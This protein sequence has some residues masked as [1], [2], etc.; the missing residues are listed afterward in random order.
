MDSVHG[1]RS[2]RYDYFFIYAIHFTT[3]SPSFF[4]M[5]ICGSITCFVVLLCVQLKGMTTI[6]R[7]IL[8]WLSDSFQDL[9]EAV[10][11]N[12]SEDSNPNLN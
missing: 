1:G 7:K 3:S 12:L 11:R 4:Q 6:Y 9:L 8:I 2:S 10:T 5:L